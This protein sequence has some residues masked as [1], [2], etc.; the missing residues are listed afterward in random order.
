MIQSCNLSITQRDI[1]VS[2]IGSKSYVEK[3][4]LPPKISGSISYFASD[5][6]NEKIM[7]LNVLSPLDL[8]PPSGSPPVELTSLT[9]NLQSKSYID[10]D[11]KNMFFNNNLF[12]L[13]RKDSQDAMEAGDLDL[14]EFSVMGIGNC[15]AES[16]SFECS[17]GSTPTS[18]INF[19][20]ETLTIQQYDLDGIFVPSVT[21]SGTPSPYDFKINS[22]IYQLDRDGF[23]NPLTE[24]E[25]PYPKTP[26]S[27]LKTEVFITGDSIGILSGDSTSNS[28][29][30]QSVSISLDLP[31]TE[32]NSISSKYIL[33]KPYLYPLQGS[34]SLSMVIEDYVVGDTRFYENQ[35]FDIRVSVKGTEVDSP[36]CSLDLSDICI[37]GA[38]IKSQSFTQGV[39][40]RMLWNADLAFEEGESTDVFDREFHG[41]LKG[42][43]FKGLYGLGGEEIV[44]M[45]GGFNAM[46]AEDSWIMDDF[47]TTIGLA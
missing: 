35:D 43:F 8:T 38:R 42:I 36:N 45:N 37:I 2:G 12:M 40:G 27:P 31:R 29:N 41:G 6:Y 22:D 4:A 17:V 10:D 1:A 30:L 32:L 7:G 24:T 5:G 16:Y 9:N 15:Y 21:Q 28:V 39:G 33:D 46:L 34:V 25:S 18:S 26:A 13:T 23:L 19:S 20:A 3:K 47:S 14:E 11:E 44:A